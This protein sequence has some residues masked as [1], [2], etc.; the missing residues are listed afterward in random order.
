VE[1]ATLH[2]IGNAALWFQSAEDKMGK[3]T[4]LQL[5]DT[6]NKRFDWGQYQQLY[7]KSFRIRQTSSV[8]EYIEQF[9][10]LMHHMLAYKPDIDP[11]FFTTHFIDGLRKDLRASVLIQCPNDLDSA[12]SL[13]LL[14]EEIGEDEDHNSPPSKFSG[15]S[16]INYKA[17]SHSPVQ[18]DA[19][20][21]KNKQGVLSDDRKVTDGIRTASS[22]QKL[23][24]LKS[25]RKAMGLCFKC[26][27]EWNQQHKCSV[28]AQLHLIE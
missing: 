12:V 23:A 18:S 3:V 15:Y 27:E 10:I 22:T 13:A 20:P 7:R 28:S 19:T 26:G 1:Y 14:Q 9:D 25:Y 4:W 24:A 16:R 2:F 8:T 11:T 17:F 5:C 21:A 6:I